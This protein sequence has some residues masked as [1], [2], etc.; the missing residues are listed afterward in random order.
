MT[1]TTVRYFTTFEVG[2]ICAVYH[3][4]VIY[5]VNKGKLKAHCT[6]GGHRRIAAP[7]LANFM[8]RHDM[9]IPPN[10]AL[11]PKR[12]LVVEDDPGVQRM[13]VR[14]LES[15]P[16]LDIVTCEKG[17]EALMAIGKEPP[18]LL[19]LDLKI[20]QV[21][22]YEVCRLLRANDNTKPI[23]V[24]VVSGDLLTPEN[25]A[26]LRGHTDGFFPKPLA[27]ADFRALAADLLELDA[28]VAVSP[29]G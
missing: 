2:K 9:P 14:A 24:I 12:V 27:T 8:E 16:N 25:E 13:L 17:L 4:T 7:D 19:V 10:L 5:W 6:P 29:E 1:I 20:P 15:L 11:R 28:A 18:D 21:N 26:F 23:K 22:G 3:T